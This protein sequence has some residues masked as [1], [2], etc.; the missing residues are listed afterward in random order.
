[1][2][3]FLSRQGSTVSRTTRHDVQLEVHKLQVTCFISYRETA[4]LAF[5]LN[6]QAN[7]CL[8]FLSHLLNEVLALV[9]L[10]VSIQEEIILIFTDYDL[11]LIESTTVESRTR[12][13]TKTTTAITDTISRTTT[14]SSSPQKN[15]SSANTSLPRTP[16]PAPSTPQLR[17]PGPAPSTPQLRS[18]V[19]QI[20]HPDE[21]QAP[22]PGFSPEGFYVVSVGQAVGIFYHW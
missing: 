13:W 1:V 16:R 22:E 7:L 5:P 17:S 4:T 15:H 14:P 6:H 2:T 21:I 11:I 10:D 19:P 12:T 18:H 8:Q 3:N 9:R 20:P